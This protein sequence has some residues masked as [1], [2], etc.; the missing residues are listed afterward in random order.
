MVD[1]FW[2][3]TIYIYNIYIYIY[4]IYI[5][6]LYIYIYSVG[7]TLQHQK[8]IKKS[9]TQ[10]PILFCTGL[11]TSWLPSNRVLGCFISSSHLGPLF[12]LLHTR[13]IWIR[14]SASAQK[15]AKPNENQPCGMLDSCKTSTAK[16]VIDD[17]VLSEAA[18]RLLMNQNR[19]NTL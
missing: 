1:F 16:S 13:Q 6:I 10:L 12:H 5:Y 19:K 2:G 8:H 18:R 9:R 4:I 17:T 15:H 3:G 7:T 11:Q 14:S